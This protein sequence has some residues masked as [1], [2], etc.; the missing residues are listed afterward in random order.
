MKLKNSYILLITAIIL[1]ISMGSVC[2][3][4][5][6]NDTLA[7]E[8][9]QTDSIL[10]DEGTTQTKINTTVNVP[11]DS[12]KIKNDTNF[13]IPMEVKDNASNT[14]NVNE[15]NFKIVLN[16]V[17]T[18][19][20]TVSNNTFT[21]L[22]KL[23]VGNHSLLIT[24]LGNDTYSGSAKRINL[25][26]YH[27]K[28]LEMPSEIITEDGLNVII[29]VK[30]TDGLTD[31]IVNTND[32][33]INLT[34]KDASGNIHSIIRTYTTDNKNNITLNL[35]V[36]GFLQA[37]LTVNLTESG[38]SKK[39]AVKIKT[40]VEASDIRF[41]TDVDKDVQVKVKNP[42]GGDVSVGQASFILYEGSKI[43]NFTYDPN[44]INVIT[45]N[46]NLTQSYHNITIHYRGDDLYAS[47][48][49]SILVGIYGD[50][51][52]EVEP[53]SNVDSNK[54]IH[55]QLNVT[56]GL[57][58]VVI[59]SYY[60]K[61]KVN[62]IDE[63]NQ[64]QTKDIDVKSDMINQTSQIVTFDF[65]EKFKKANLT[66]QYTTTGGKVVVK[67]VTVKV[68]TQ[69]AISDE[70]IIGNLEDLNISAVITAGDGQALIIN[71]DNFKL[72]NGNKAINITYNNSVIVIHDKLALGTY[73]LTAKFTGNETYSDATKDF[74]FKIIGFKT[75]A[76]SLD[77]NSTL[78]GEFKLNVTDGTTV[79]DVQ[80][81]DL[82]IIANYIK[83]NDTVN[84]TIKSFEIKNNTLYITFADG[85]FTSANLTMTYKK[86]TQLKLTLNRIYNVIIIP[87][88]TS[89]D[90]QD[91]NFTFNVT[92]IDTNSPLVNKSINVVIKYNNTSCYFI[93]S[94]S[95]GSISLN[96]NK[97]YT[98]DE[99]GLLVVNNSGFNPGIVIADVVYAPVGEYEITLTGTSG[100]KGTNSTKLNIN[101][102][103]PSIKLEK[104]DE[105]YGTDKKV[106]ITVTNSKTGKALSGV[107][108]YINL[109]DASLSNPRQITNSKGQIELGV[110][111]LPA[112]TY[113]LSF[114][115]NDTSIS[116]V[117]GSGSFKISRIPIVI[118][119]KDV[120]MYY[121]SG[122]TSTIKITH[123]G[124]AVSGV[125]ILVR[126]YSTS[127]KYNDYLFQ[128]DKKG[129]IAFSAPLN[130]GK[131]KM[132]VVS[133]DNRYDAKQVNKVITVKKATAKL[134]APKVTAYY[135]DG[136]SFVVKLTNKKNKKAIYG[137]KVKVTLTTKTLRYKPITLTTGIDGKG[138]LAI[139]LNPG[140]YNVKVVGAESKNYKAS[141]ITSKIVVKK[142]SA[143]LSP[144]KLTAKKGS[145][146]YFQVK[147][148]NKKTKKVISGLKLK[149]KVK[150]KTY[151]IK[152][153][154]KGFAKLST[155]SL[156]VGTYKVTVK[157]ADK[158]C[159]A[160]TAK[161]TIKIKK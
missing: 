64:N 156:K 143:K 74:V 2:A 75:N 85:N 102:V 58:P 43:L 67:N 153:N 8:D 89:A 30:V 76:T 68:D 60:L 13:A 159:V 84:V 4:D 138:R 94:G 126:L 98:T 158:Y 16:N 20:F 18:T 133:A 32:L 88:S 105:Y 33:E 149:F 42:Q 51:V 78:V 12:Y 28:T 22:E 45:I 127:S 73:N 39:A 100:V 150:S 86:N 99:K 9:D 55:L 148:T 140:T 72:Y 116:T 48:N 80:A 123:N 122:T 82:E 118:N 137:A 19:K 23:A 81:S 111:S 131:H 128:T 103:T 62:Y 107:Y 69:I 147:V 50:D 110:S 92:D 146:S 65:A 142:T 91:G 160:K 49:K 155:K 38:A 7:V 77:V 6:A 108:A 15:S 104:F 36:P 25:T 109:T 132:I 59:S 21:L 70:I 27:D 61:I 119:A 56:N 117:S 95:G 151:H 41:S 87:I 96:T 29:P 141:S 152:T 57:D 52:F 63:N 154:S 145:K 47:S 31:Y 35:G 125:Y 37:N 97:V 46:S 71:T 115:T 24:Y 93:V 129:Q 136:K 54:Q 44:R 79:Y 53:A 17:T 144:K 11:E 26:V 130:V 113:K 10:A 1:L 134:S 121:N 66:V 3:S 34:Y 120:T 135:K 124:A 5:D 90:F 139:T 114:F 161:S 40:T 101:M 14:I 112:N 106:T 83:G 157:S